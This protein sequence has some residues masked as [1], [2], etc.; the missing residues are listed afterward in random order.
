[1]GGEGVSGW[2][3][4]GGTWYQVGDSAILAQ[5]GSCERLAKDFGIEHGG[6]RMGSGT[7]VGGWI[8]D[9]LVFSRILC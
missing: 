1:M 6:R 8:L 4:L 7:S 9:T 3:S 2:R 5:Q